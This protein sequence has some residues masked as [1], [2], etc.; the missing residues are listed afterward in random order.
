VIEPLRKL[1]KPSDQETN[2]SGHDRSMH[3]ISLE[4]QLLNV[5]LLYGLQHHS[6]ACSARQQSITKTGFDRGPDSTWVA[7]V[8]GTYSGNVTIYACSQCI[9]TVHTG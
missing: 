8:W 9:T 5:G 2:L 3:G 4:M 7:H 1:D 6:I